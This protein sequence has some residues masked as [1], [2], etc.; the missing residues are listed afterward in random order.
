MHEDPIYTKVN[1]PRYPQTVGRIELAPYHGMLT[2]PLD[3]V[4]NT[5]GRG[6]SFQKP[7]LDEIIVII[8]KHK[9]MR[10]EENL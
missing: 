6:I 9:K 1:D 4:M 3:E 2:P 10:V 5:G 8:I 7:P